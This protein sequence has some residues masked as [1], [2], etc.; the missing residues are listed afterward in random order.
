ML[1]CQLQG[2]EYPR[3][4]GGSQPEAIS[5]HIKQFA[6]AWAGGA[7]LW[8]DLASDGADTHCRGI[9]QHITLRLYFGKTADRQPLLDFFRTVAVAGSSTG[10]VMLNRASVSAQTG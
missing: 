1:E 2:F 9:C 3:P 4:L 8:H 10:K 6:L 5:H 7:G